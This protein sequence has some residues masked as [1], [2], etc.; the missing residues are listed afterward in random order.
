MSAKKPR[1]VKKIIE[2]A[3][4]KVSSDPGRFP[5]LTMVLV[6]L[7]NVGKSSLINALRHVSG[8]RGSVST[9]APHAGVT[10]AIQTRVRIHDE[11][12]V[13]LV[14]TPGILDP[15]LKGPMQMLRIALTGG[16]KDSLIDEVH[17]ADYLLYRLNQVASCRQ[18]YT[19][20][21]NIG[22]T[23]DIN[24]LLDTVI[25]NSRKPA[26]GKD[27]KRPRLIHDTHAAALSF[28]QAFREGEFGPLTLD[29]CT[30]EGLEHWWER[31]ADDI[32]SRKELV[33]RQ[34]CEGLRGKINE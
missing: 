26:A 1:L 14:D 25:Q 9:V 8:H 18:K 29:D 27:N 33:N 3:L 30:T 21:L 32:I 28:I 10:R 15:N 11:P 12:P 7:P 4:D 6:G 2:F 31:P 19:T 24:F 23:N 17:V 5:F 13:Y 22:P 34:E 20:S 16:T